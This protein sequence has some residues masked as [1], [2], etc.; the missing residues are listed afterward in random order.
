LSGIAVVY[1]ELQRPQ[2]LLLLLVQLLARHPTAFSA[3]GAFFLSLLC[4]LKKYLCLLFLSAASAVRSENG[5]GRH[6]RLLVTL[7]NR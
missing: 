2:L 7:L 4:F 6:G 3:L 1:H 5:I